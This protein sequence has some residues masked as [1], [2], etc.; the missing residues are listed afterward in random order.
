M[1]M[2]RVAVLGVLL[3]V[4]ALSP[5][6]AAPIDPFTGDW[7][8]VVLDTQASEHF[9]PADLDL[10]VSRNGDGFSLR[11]T[12]FEGILDREDFVRESFRARFAPSGR[13]GVY[14]YDDRQQSLLS[15]MFASPET[16]NPLEGETLLWGRIEEQTLV[17]YALHLKDDG[18]FELHRVEVTR[19]GE[20]LAVERSIRTGHR[21]ITILAGRLARAE[22]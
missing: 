11:W 3:S 17:A 1:H 20:E 12:A 19:E 5:L 9:E 15:R 6:F 2:I 4:P 7:R 21:R 22:N 16:G 8:G 13:T 10:K 14:A 18:E